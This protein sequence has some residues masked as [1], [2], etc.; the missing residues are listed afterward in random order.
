MLSDLEL[1]TV[2]KNVIVLEYR[3]NSSI[4]FEIKSLLSITIGNITQE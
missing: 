4:S 3:H 2:T 1:D